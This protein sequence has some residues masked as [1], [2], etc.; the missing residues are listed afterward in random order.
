[1]D[2]WI[3]PITILP[4]A[5]LLIMS[6]TNLIHSLSEEIDHL[7][8]H[9]DNNTELIF[10]KINQLDLLNK[11][12]VGFY[13]SAGAFTLAGIMLGLIKIINISEPIGF[14]IIGGGVL[15][16]FISLILLTIYSFRSVKIRKSQFLD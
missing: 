14:L 13:V 10:K 16:I 8:H 15:L 3:F 9:H 2:S 1:M 6:T 5:G 4:G 12:L 7:H 11:A